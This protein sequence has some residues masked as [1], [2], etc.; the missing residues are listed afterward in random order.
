MSS[1]QSKSAAAAQ[2]QALQDQTRKEH[3]F[4]EMESALPD[5][6]LPA[7]QSAFSIPSV[8]NFSSYLGSRNPF[9]RPVSGDDV[10]WL[11]D[12]T[13][14][15]PG[16]LSSWQAEFVAAVFEKEPKAKVVDMVTS[17]AETLGLADDAEELAT[18]EERLLPFLWDV[19]PARHLRIVHQDREI[20]LGPTGRNGISTD[21]LKLSEQ[22]TGTSVKASAAVPRGISGELEMQTHFAAAEGWAVL[23]DVDDTIKVTQTSSPLG[24]LRKTFVDP[25]SAVPGMPELYRHI[26]SLIS[27]E[28]PWFYLSASPYNLYPFLRNFCRQWYPHGTLILRDSSWRTI[29]GLLSALTKGTEQY[30][31]DR[32]RKVH[33]WLPKRKLILI[34]DSTQSDPEAYGD[35]YREFDGWVKLILIRKVTDIAAVG[36]ESKNE[37]KRFEEAFKDVPREAWHI[38]EDP[39]E[40]NKIVEKVV[41]GA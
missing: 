38:F 12:N 30:K 5:P 13:A 24:I 25:P 9:G 33:S 17:I 4:D 11:F 23:S 6:R 37:P 35:I 20:K 31:T 8:D 22:P 3:K 14:F 32:I 10:V 15:K 7:L 27:K 2:A 16:R 19:R 21:I 40:C 18:I 1:H 29:A 41:A 28:A 34:G 39:A 26:T 36:I